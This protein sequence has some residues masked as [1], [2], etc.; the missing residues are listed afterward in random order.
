MENIYYVYIMLDIRKP[1]N[2]KYKNFNFLYEPIYIGKGKKYR[3]NTHFSKNNLYKCGNKLKTNKILKIKLETNKFPKI[4]KLY[5]N[6]THSSACRMEK[7][8]IKTIGRLDINTG[9]LVNLT[10][11][12]EGS[13][14]RVLS[15]NTKIKIGKANKG[16][17]AW[18]KGLN[19]ETDY[20]IYKQSEVQKGH[21]HSIETIEKLTIHNK[22]RA[23]LDSSKKRFSEIMN[24]TEVKQKRKETFKNGSFF[25]LEK[26]GRWKDIDKEEFIKLYYSNLPYKEIQKILNVSQPW[27]SRRIKLWNLK[28]RN[29]NE[30]RKKGKIQSQ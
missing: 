19:K 7:L 10:D 24:S 2:Y 1:G 20:R 18:N 25:K 21:K 14:K 9:P 8:L 12:G 28:H 13:H 16:N 29:K 4:Y 22:K 27:I 26:N 30:V 5:T 17:P 3:L 23:N 11:G 6:L 15:E